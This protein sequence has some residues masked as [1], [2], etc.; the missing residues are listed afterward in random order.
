VLEVVGVGR[1]DA[2]VTRFAAARFELP[3]WVDETC[4]DSDRSFD[5]IES[6][7]EFVIELARR[8]ASIGEGGPFGAAVFD[9][10]TDRLVAPGVNLVVPAMSAIAHAEIVAIGV[11]GAS[12]Q[13]YDL[14]AG[15]KRRVLVAST[16]PCA[17]CFGA[18][19]WSGVTR[20]VCCA[21]DEDARS[22]GFDEGP[23][24]DRW[25]IELESRGIEVVRDIHRDEA[26]AVLI[27]YAASGGAIYN[28]RQG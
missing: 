21:R 26:A 16:E 5:G 22:V 12:E 23:K 6:K 13:H 8:N 24:M 11:A 2:G 3:V 17:M 1:N 15:G 25:W 4:G 18:V 14:S 28:G 19:P 10:D 27:E 7:A 20:L 9:L